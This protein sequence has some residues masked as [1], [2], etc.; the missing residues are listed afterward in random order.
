MGKYDDAAKR[1]GA[2][3][4]K[5]FEDDIIALK[6]SNLEKMFPAASDRKYMEEL[7]AAVDKATSKNELNLAFQ[8]F[9]A[10]ATMEGLKALKEG[11]KIAKKLVI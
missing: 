5:E 3:V 4:M 1:A 9:G 2:D 10:K 7:I 6:T 8:A 11:F